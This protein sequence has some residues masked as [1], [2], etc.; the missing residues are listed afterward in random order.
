M[1]T[2]VAFSMD[3]ITSIADGIVPEVVVSTLI[4]EGW[5]GTINIITVW[6]RNVLTY[7]SIS[8]WEE[9]IVTGDDIAF[10]VGSIEGTSQGVWI[11][12]GTQDTLVQVIIPVSVCGCTFAFISAT[13]VQMS[14][15]GAHTLTCLEVG[16]LSGRA[17]VA[18]SIVALDRVTVVLDAV[19]VGGVR[20]LELVAS[21][22]VR[23]GH[24]VL[25]V[26][27]VSTLDTILQN[28]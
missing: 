9:P 4:T 26:L 1:V 25:S 3:A 10:R 22:T 18:E 12:V 20:G 7:S 15:T 6:N 27:I 23:A 8:T 16:E 17:L 5:I 24:L 14:G 13:I 19:G 11:D 21:G 28:V 2:G